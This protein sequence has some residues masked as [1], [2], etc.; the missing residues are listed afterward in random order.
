M[1]KSPSMDRLDIE[2]KNFGPITEAKFDL[3]PLTLFIGPSNSGKSYLSTLI[4][5]LHRALHRSL[6][7]RPGLLHGSGQGSVDWKF[8]EEHI[9]QLQGWF[10]KNFG[11]P[12]DDTSTDQNFMPVR[13]N[14]E[15]P[16]EISQ[17]ICEALNANSKFDVMLED[18]IER[19]FGAE[20]VESLIQY[21]GLTQRST[22]R[23]ATITLKRNAQCHQNPLKSIVYNFELSAKNSS[24]SAS[25][26]PGMPMRVWAPEHDLSIRSLQEL[27]SSDYLFE[28]KKYMAD[29]CEQIGM[30]IA[31]SA[32]S[33]SIDPIGRPAH[34]L[35]ADRTGI[36]HT[37]RIIVNS[38]VERTTRAGMYPLSLSGVLVDFLEQLVGINDP[39]GSFERRREIRYSTMRQLHKERFQKHY[40]L[41]RPV[42]TELESRV[43]GGVVHSEA[44]SGLAISYPEFSYTPDGWDDSLPLMLASSMVSEL[45]PIVLYLRS[46]VLPGDVLIIEEPEAHLHP[47]LQIEFVNVLAEIVKLGVQVI[48]TTHSV[49]V[50]DAVANLVLSSDTGK[51]GDNDAGV[52]LSRENVGIWSFNQKDC[53][54]G[55]VVREIEF[56]PDEGGYVTEF[57]DAAMDLHNNWVRIDRRINKKNEELSDE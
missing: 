3:R 4:Y 9:H 6:S 16:E 57:D 38:A 20:S 17:L 10:G 19:C 35:P 27:L 54:K 7:D 1:T 13:K 25:V 41:L 46:V 45:S 34:Y 32:F 40:K 44:S 28:E 22:S 51:R 11:A 23:K 55:S 2:V 39:P 42:A 49:W 24:C 21:T 33:N 53:P 18:E 14:F 8:S 47:N 29:Y 56:D 15:L 37:H 43:L 50:L 36:M 12:P 26:S 31:N 30:D 52:A 5:A 48:L